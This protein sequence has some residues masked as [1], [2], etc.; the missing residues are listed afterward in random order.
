MA[1]ATSP[2]VLISIAAALGA[3]ATLLGD[4]FSIGALQEG[5][6]GAGATTQVG[7]AGGDGGGGG[8]V[9]GGGGG[10]GGGGLTHYACGWLFDQHQLVASMEGVNGE[11]WQGEPLALRVDGDRVRA[12]TERSTPN[13]KIV[14]VFTLQQGQPPLE[15]SFPARDLY[16]LERTSIASI[17]ALY[18]RD[19]PDGP[20]LTLAN[21]GDGDPDGGGAY[22]RELTIQGLGAFPSI[23]PSYG[24]RARFAPVAGGS[25]DVDFVVGYRQT[26]G[27]YV[28]AYG[29]YRGTA[30]TAVRITPNNNS[31]D[32]N[33]NEPRLLVNHQGQSFAFFGE[34][35]TPAGTRQFT[36]DEAV[37]GWQT[38]RA[39]TP[40]DVFVL[41]AQ[42][43][44]GSTNVL[45][46]SGGPPLT[47]LAGKIDNSTLGEVNFDGLAVLGT[48]ESLLDL[49]MQ[50]AGFGWLG[51]VG[52]FMGSDFTDE[53]QA[54]YWLFDVEG[55]ERGIAN[56]PFT[57]TLAPDETRQNGMSSLTVTRRYATF[58][59]S[60]GFA[61][62]IW[63]E[64]HQ[65]PN[66]N[67]EVIYYDQLACVPE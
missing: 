65:R 40:A 41:G 30:V 21:I 17:G 26:S 18:T 52:I 27:N 57:A 60:Q 61:H 29:A 20:I 7:G 66:D 35:D 14:Q 45:G 53:T 5:G 33:A 48:Y 12:L 63:T 23:D 10:V 19:D 31:P 44:P 11:Y 38:P 51:D 55:R 34:P 24:V 37:T 67:Y 3:C 4:D 59:E 16:Q 13:G 62:V 22:H 56:L 50:V 64:Y 32:N 8:S 58:D 39:L 36:L 25:S 6:G 42:A 15:S 43:G 28:E 49:P 54:R 9:G 2:L 47:L 46:F 1:S